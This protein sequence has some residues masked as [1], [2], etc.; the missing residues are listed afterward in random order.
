MG[1]LNANNV[2]KHIIELG[3]KG[4]LDKITEVIVAHH[5]KN[6]DTI[7]KQDDKYD[8]LR[9]T[10]K[11][12]IKKLRKLERNKHKYYAKINIDK[13]EAT[14]SIYSVLIA[15]LDILNDKQNIKGQIDAAY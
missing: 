7:Q 2:W 15:R 10:E 8:Y 1:R 13:H 14:L 4:D 6:L 11:D 3:N 9:A 12:F 5:L